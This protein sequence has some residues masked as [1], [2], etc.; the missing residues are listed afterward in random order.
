MVAQPQFWRASKVHAPDQHKYRTS[1]SAGSRQRLS[2]ARA[3]MLV[4]AGFE[5]GGRSHALAPVADGGLHGHPFG[6]W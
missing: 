1:L 4:D 5:G 3:G 6:G 2:E